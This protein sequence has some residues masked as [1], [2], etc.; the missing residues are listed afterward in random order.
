[1][2]KELL[3]IQNADG[4]TNKITL[5]RKE[6]NERKPV[7]VVFPAMGVRA[8][9][10]E[11]LGK[12]LCDL[13]YNCVTADLRGHGNSNIRPS[14]K[15]DFGYAE[16]LAQEYESVF[17]KVKSLFPKNDLYL[18]GHSLGGQLGS[19]YAAKNSNRFKGLILIACCSVYYKGWSGIRKYGNLV[20]TQFMACIA[21]VLGF[22]PGKHIGF[23]GLEAKSVMRDWSRQARTGK[24]RLKKDNFDYENALNKLD[25]PVLAISFSGDAYAP[26]KAV[27][28]LL[29]K[30]TASKNVVHLHLKKENPH[31]DNY[32]H[33]NW[34]KKPF[35]LVDAVNKWLKK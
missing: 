24:Y 12:A 1:M 9:Y 28:N 22:F 25:I 16:M 2:N 6:E 30:F 15:Q 34:A 5:F 18:L 4:S 10:Y 13:G 17:Q 14:R 20:A 19:L 8:A 27:K 29:E 26:Q 3:T 31:N 21:T 23:G 35:L 32:N 7:I 11:S 33:F